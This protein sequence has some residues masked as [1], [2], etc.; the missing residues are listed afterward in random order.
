MSRKADCWDNP[1]MESAIGT[2]KV[3]CVHEVAFATRA[4]VQRAI[5]ERLGYYNTDRLHLSLGDLTPSEFE[6]RW[7][8]DHEGATAP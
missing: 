3:E 5:V 1:P 2:V 8:A 6:R 4:Q 7:R